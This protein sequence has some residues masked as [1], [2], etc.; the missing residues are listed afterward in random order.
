[1]KKKLYNI[2]GGFALLAAMAL[3]LTSCENDDDSNPTLDLSQSSTFVLNT[4]ATAA[5]NT[6]DLASAN[7]I[8]LT[9]SQPN[10]GGVP[11]VT[12]YYVQVSLDPTF[13]TNT[14]AA[15]KE[16]STYYTTASMKVDAS[17]MNDA[18]VNLYKEANPDTDYPNEARKVYVRLR[19]IIDGTNLGE[20]F[21]NVITLPSVLATYVAPKAEFVDQLY[22]V[23]ADIQE[24]WSSWKVVPQIYGLKG[25]YYT[26]IYVS[27]GGTFKWGTFNNDWRGYNRFR[28]VTDEAGS[29]IKAEDEDNNNLKIEKAGWYVL[30]IRGEIVGNSIQYDLTVYPGNAYVIG[31]A[32]GFWDDASDALKMTAP[33]SKDGLWVSPAFTASAEM[34]AYVKVPGFDWWRTEF[35][36]FEGSLYWRN[37]D[38]PDSWAGNVGA[39]YSVSPKPGQKLYVNFNQNTGK[40]E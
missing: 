33:D 34:R 36:L 12:R 10:Y 21:S 24:A 27:A 30:Y 2:V 1:M 16:L 11:Y 38:I 25:N 9:C 8:V 23:G 14:E 5:N 6:Y 26:M 17:E 40:V 37:V 35:T 32:I 19:A 31:N 20:S 18:V 15:F 22:V 7:N 29:G 3:T 28:T 4:P 39:A 13:G